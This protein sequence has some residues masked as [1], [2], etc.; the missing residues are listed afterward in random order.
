MSAKR[1]RDWRRNRGK[2]K[3]HLLVHIFRIL[4]DP[5]DLRA[6]WQ[7]NTTFWANRQA[8]LDHLA[9][10]WRHDVTRDILR[11]KLRR[12]SISIQREVEDIIADCSNVEGFNAHQTD[13][14]IVCSILT[15]SRD[16]NLGDYN[17][18]VPT[19]ARNT[20]KRA[21]VE[22]NQRPEAQRPAQRQRTSPS[23]SLI[24]STN[25]SIGSFL[26]YAVPNATN[27][28]S[29]PVTVQSSPTVEQLGFAAP[30]FLAPSPNIATMSGTPPKLLKPTCDVLLKYHNKNYILKLNT[31]ANVMWFNT[32]CCLK[33]NW[34][35]LKDFEYYHPVGKVMV[36]I[37]DDGDV[38][39][40]I[41]LALKNKDSLLSITAYDKVDDFSLRQ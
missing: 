33:L 34:R 9:T 20:S 2:G 29:S 6:V 18:L 40:V 4:Q 17:S 25:P 7:T 27:I 14:S 1:T 32:Y 15:L 31:D 22:P 37:V 26:S 35:D 5:N 23:T 16:C 11:A 19:T 21:R 12:Y 13:E 41:E 10:T 36:G 30:I 24:R 28:G 38:G 3:G 39:D 8:L